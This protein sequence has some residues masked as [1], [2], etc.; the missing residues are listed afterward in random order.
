MRRPYLL[1]VAFL[2]MQG[3]L[4]AGACSSGDA[5]PSACAPNDARPCACADGRSGISRCTAAGDGYGACACDTSDGG[6]E[7]ASDAPDDVLDGPGEADALLPFLAPC[8]TNA[9]CETGLCFPFPSKGPHCTKQCTSGADCPAPSP[10]CN[11]MG[12]CRVP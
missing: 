5:G 4:A 3:A 2:S 12:I 9:E 7:E 11:P 8:S 6:G 10:G 1:L